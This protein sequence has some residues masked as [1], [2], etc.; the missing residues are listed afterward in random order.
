MAKKKIT[1]LIQLRNR[2]RRVTAN[3][4]LRQVFSGNTSL[5]QDII[6]LNT[7]D[8]L[9]DKGV[10]AKGK[11]LGEYAFI[12]R[13]Y[14]KPLAATQGRDGRSDH[15][16]LKDTGA[17]YRSFKF[18]GT[19]ESFYF[20]AD[21]IKVNEFGSRTDLIEQFGNVIGLTNE[22]QKKVAKWIIPDCRRVV[23]GILTSK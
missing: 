19:A 4:V 11:E 17:F 9:Y 21:T 2:M 5:Q 8:Q 1:A 16:T 3:R 10:D 13:T 15:V 6:E 20:T 18:R 23:R 22:N 7:E 12:T 14:Y